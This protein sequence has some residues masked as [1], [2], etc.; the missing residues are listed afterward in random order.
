MPGI[1]PLP[2]CLRFCR[3]LA[4]NCCKIPAKSRKI[5]QDLAGMQEKGPFL[6]RS[7]TCIFTGGLIPGSCAKYSLHTGIKIMY[8]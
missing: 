2:Y 4:Q 8:L 3:N 6:V 7:C 1:M 5:L